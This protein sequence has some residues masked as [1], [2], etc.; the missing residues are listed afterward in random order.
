MQTYPLKD[1]IDNKVSNKPGATIFGNRIY[2]GQSLY[3]YLIEFLLIF[4][5]AKSEDYETGKM[6]FHDSAEEGM[7]YW[8]EPRMGL[9]RF[10]FFEK[11][12][13]GKTVKI[14]EIAYK[15][16]ISLLKSKIQ[17]ANDSETEEII[18]GLQDLIR[19]YAV[20]IK[21]RYWCAPAVLPICPELVFCEV[22]PNEKERL[23]L[24]FEDDNTKADTSFVF[25]QRNFLGRGGE[26]YYLHLL[27]GLEGNPSAKKRLEQL[28]QETL[29]NE[30][31]SISNACNTIQNT[32][33]KEIGL[34][35]EQAHKQIRLSFIPESAY[36]DISVYS[37]QELTTYLSNKIDPIIKIEV[38][39]KG[40][41]FQIM[42]MM[43]AAVGKYL[44]EPAKPWIIDM[45]AADSSAV[46]KIAADAYSKVENAFLS[47]INMSAD[48]LGLTD[49]DKVKA[50]EDSRKDSLDVF[51]SKGKELQCII[52]VKGDFTRFTLSEDVIRF[53]VLSLVEPKE[54]MTLNQFLDKLFEHYGIVIGPNQFRKLQKDDDGQKDSC[55]SEFSKNLEAFQ[56]FLKDTG[57]LHELSDATSIVENP[58][59]KIEE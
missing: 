18:E 48:A 59:A 47:A 6:K 34:T 14:D 37:I 1:D 16:M 50:V 11:S 29:T 22:M 57:F 2:R 55:T 35:D 56:S 51:R 44:N 13:K 20:V 26:V 4:V 21:N 15:K 40:I 7:S 32:W 46:R 3:E 24:K 54:K 43:N 5:S 36:K 41:M 12:N 25:D 33:A 31:K 23:K 9:K 42:R 10:V 39:A 45:K 27:Q 19:G 30:C 8:C 38:L 52:P 58:Y 17:D 49:K 53:L 28:L